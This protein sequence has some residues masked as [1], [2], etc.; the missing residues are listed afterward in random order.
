MDHLERAVA[1][2]GSGN[3]SVVV[4]LEKAFAAFAEARFA[5]CVAS[6]TSAL[7]AAC[8]AVGVRSGD[9]VGVSALGPVMSGQAILAL[10]ARPVFLDSVSESSFGL[11]AASAAEAI[12]RGVK[13]VIVVPM[14][15]YWDEQPAALSLFRRNGVPVIADA[16]QAP[17]L[18][19]RAGLLHSADIACLSL[20]AR[21]PL[22]AGEGG[23]CLTNDRQYAERIVSVRNFGQQANPNEGHLVPGG[24]FGAHC[25]VNMKMNALGAAWCLSQMDHLDAIRTRLDLL[26]GYALDA[27]GAAGAAWREASV[28]AAVLEHGRYGIVA[29][30]G[31]QH[32][33]E[34]L[35]SALA[36]QG[37]EADTKRFAYR[38]MYTAPCFRHADGLCPIAEQLTQ[39]AVACRLED[40]A[41]FLPSPD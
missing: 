8:R 7:I 14:W 28:A 15:G 35:T 3:S 41:R 17:F 6:G 24:P 29:I 27:F 25:G 16:A 13:A 26:R 20:H 36:G 22:R 37:I 40:F 12:E 30:C 23:V 21:K 38:P 39:V 5:L 2:G 19:L 32:N 34:H 9:L 18:K 10:G 1:E 31:S 4:D 33:A 11:S